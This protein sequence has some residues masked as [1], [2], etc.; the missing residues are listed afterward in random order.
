M[1]AT[2]L[3]EQRNFQGNNCGFFERGVGGGVN[4]FYLSISEAL[5]GSGLVDFHG[6][7]Y[8]RHYS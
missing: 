8:C 7:I 6:Y 2:S 5:M 4:S 1:S 3:Q